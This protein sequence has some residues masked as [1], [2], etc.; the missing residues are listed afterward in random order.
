MIDGLRSILR[1][2]KEEMAAFLAELIS[3][4]TENPPGREYERC[5]HV[6]GK[7]LETLGFSPRIERIPGDGD[8][9]ACPRFWLHCDWGGAG[10]AVVFHGHVDVVPAQDP[11]Q[12]RPRVSADTIFGRG[13]SDMKGGL[14]SMIYAM[15]ALSGTGHSPK[16][17]L[18]L[19]VV[20]DEETGGAR[21]SRALC[22]RGLLFEPDT[23]AMFT[24]EP[25]GSV[26][27]HASRGAITCRVTIKGRS[28]HVGLQYRGVNAFE[29]M[30]VA[31]A[32]LREL[33]EEVETRGTGYPIEPAEAGRSIL[34]MGGE[35]GGGSSF[36]LVPD[37]FRFTID[38][39]INPEED[40]DTEKERLLACLDSVRKQGVDLEVDVFQQASSAG[41]SPDHPVARTLG[42]AIRDAR[43]E[44]ARFELCPGI[45][46]IRF[47]GE[48]GV[49]AFAYG[50]GL[51]S[52]SHGPNEFIKRKELED[53]ALV[54][55]L[56][57]AR[58]L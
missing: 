24:A 45:L 15:A 17:K 9:P 37:E 13:S 3:V 44:E 4:P 33:K 30:L 32:A 49:P 46:E 58:L 35:S 51:L 5:L 12:F 34:M 57:A 54:Y 18:A 36:N 20:P 56:T 55:A 6:I 21:G 53:C 16:G 22:D 41:V 14:V 26:V 39:R 38:R 19:R 1:D 11:E 47:Y 42:E 48:K 23:V 43:G 50:P 7:K 2:R 25:T 31:A 52:V 28:S 8:D 27:W 29:K 10:P 40:F